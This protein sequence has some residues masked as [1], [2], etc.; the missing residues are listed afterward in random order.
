VRLLASPG[1]P[2]ARKD[3]DTRFV[4]I[5]LLQFVYLYW[6]CFN[7]FS[8]QLIGVQFTVALQSHQ[9]PHRCE[10]EKCNL[11]TGK[12]RRFTLL[13]ILHQQLLSF[14]VDMPNFTYLAKKCVE[15]PT[16]KGSLTAFLSGKMAGCLR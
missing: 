12:D 8:Y 1:K 3:K 16:T 15:G 11:Y 10:I 2:K 14:V 5:F 6:L 7:M 4:E 9:N 13:P